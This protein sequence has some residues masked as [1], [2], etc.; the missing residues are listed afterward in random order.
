MTGFPRD[1]LVID[2]LN[3]HGDGDPSVLRQAGIGAVNLTV[4]HFEGDFEQAMDGIGAWLETLRRPD[5]GWRRIG[6]AADLD[7]ARKAG[8]VGLIMGWQ[9]LRPIGDRLDRLVTLQQCGLRVA[10]L[11]YNRRN[12]LGDG[13]L[14]PED[15]GL[16]GLG[17][18]AVALMNELGIAIDL[19]HVG[20]RTSVEAAQAST[21]P[22]LATHANARA[23]T[24]ALRNKSDDAIRAIADSG[25]VIGVSIYGPMCWDGDAARHP[26]LDDFERHLDHIVALVGADHVGLGTDLPAVANLDSVRQIT[27]MTLSKFPAAIARYAAAFGNDIRARYLSDCSSHAELVRIA[28]RLQARGWSENDVRK[29]LGGN[30]A[31]AFADIWGG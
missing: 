15:G 27:E 29:L 10:Q 8:Q 6:K 12:F 4:S 18:E 19:S 1:A 14:E 16:S 24:P 2:G 21:R 30:F 22:V 3:F 28:E 9:N 23:V 25:G 13:C 20:Q 26:G 31:R 7:A 11:T 17:R 5:C